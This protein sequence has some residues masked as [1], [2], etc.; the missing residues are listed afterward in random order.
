MHKALQTLRRA[1]KGAYGIA[2][3]GDRFVVEKQRATVNGSDGTA[4]A[5]EK[6]QG[7]RGSG[8][9]AALDAQWSGDR[10]MLHMPEQGVHSISCD[11]HAL[12]RCSAA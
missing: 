11:M 4:T 2:V 5:L 7:R 9:N 6:A 1:A 3:G 10:C 8:S 12:R